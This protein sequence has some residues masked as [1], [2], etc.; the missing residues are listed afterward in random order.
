MNIFAQRIFLI[1]IGLAVVGLGIFFWFQD[2]K[3]QRRCTE[4]ATATVVDNIEEWK[5]GDEDEIE[6]VYYPVIRFETPNGV[7]EDKYKYGSSSP[8][9]EGTEYTVYYNI[10]DRHEFYIEGE[11]DGIFKTIICFIAAAIAI[12]PALFFSD[13]LMKKLND[14]YGTKPHI[15]LPGQEPIYFENKE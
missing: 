2:T 13:N 4:K 8:V 7:V 9:K 12:I 15:K 1:I 6:K 10:N 3:I 5:H 11:T 14:K